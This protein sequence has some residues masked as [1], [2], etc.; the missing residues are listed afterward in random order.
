MSSKQKT[1]FLVLIFLFFGTIS[2]IF[3]AECLPADAISNSSNCTTTPNFYRLHIYKMGLC[4]NIQPNQYPSPDS[5]PNIA[6]NCQTVFDA[7]SSPSAVTVRDNISDPVTGGNTSKPAEGVYQYGF[8]LIEGQMDVKAAK[9]FSSN[10]Q[11]TDSQGNANGSGTT[12]WTTGG[13]W[14]PAG[15]TASTV[16]GSSLDTSNYDFN[17]TNFISLDCASPSFHCSYENDP[18]NLDDTYA[19]LV[20]SSGQLSNTASFGA[21]AGQVKMLLGF[22]K[23][24][25][26]IT[27]NSSTSVFEAQFRVKRGLDVQINGSQVSFYGREFKVITTVY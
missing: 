23:F 15:S 13:T 11:G 20:D 18:E 2:E 26:P 7:G 3:A 22:A 8:V 25:T 4:N 1:M 21:G 17:I 24:R 12:C 9:T 14:T 10:K 27:I 5:V 16:C 6:T 19:Y